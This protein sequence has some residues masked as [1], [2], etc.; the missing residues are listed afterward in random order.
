MK[1]SKKVLYLLDADVL[2]HLVKSGLLPHISNSKKYFS[3]LNTTYYD[4]VI[5]NNKTIDIE[6]LEHLKIITLTSKQIGMIDSVK[7]EKNLGFHDW[8][9]I[10][11]GMENEYTIITTNDKKLFE[12]AQS[13]GATVIRLIGLLRKLHE[14][15]LIESA[16]LIKGL[17]ILKT[18]K[19]VRIPDNIINKL[20]VDILRQQK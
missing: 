20:I 9:L 5:D 8:S 17:K 16:K 14:D 11:V 2:I 18:H 1:K 6:Y 13:K 3:I 10:V 12:T 7:I 15:S 19:T 4:Q